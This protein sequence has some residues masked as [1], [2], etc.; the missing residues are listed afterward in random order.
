MAGG[1]LFICNEDLAQLSSQTA[2]SSSAPFFSLDSCCYIS[3]ISETVTSVFILLPLLLALHRD[4][5]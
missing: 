5:M 1:R 2:H 4:V 3:D